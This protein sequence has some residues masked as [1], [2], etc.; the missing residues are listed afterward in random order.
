MTMAT[1]AP[2]IPRDRFGRPLV[3]PPNGGRPVAYT[4]CTTFVS[5]LEDTFNLGKWM[6]RMVALGL[7]DRPD[8]LLSV[9]AHR[10]D[11]SQLDRLCEDAR[12]YAKA[13]AAA[14]TG[15]AL[16]ALTERIDRGQDVGVVPDAYLADLA[17]YQGA[18]EGLTAT[19][20]EQFC[21]L[22]S[23]KIGGTPDRVVKYNGK[24]YIADVKTGS[25]EYGIGKIAMQ[26][27]VYA[28]SQ[29]YDHA[30]GA[31]GDHGAE[32]DKGLIVHL[33]A[34]AG[35]CDLIWVDL[36]EGWEG[37][38]LARAV[39]DW[40]THKFADLTEPFSPAPEPAPVQAQP[41]T[42]AEVIDQCLT[43]QALGEL[44]QERHADFTPAHV[45]QAKA[46]KAAITSSP[47]S[48]GAGSTATEGAQA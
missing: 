10:D 1:I 24:R 38:K 21:V 29:T 16:H 2:E 44:W 35:T 23:L 43:V 39:R 30:T 34:G 47:S 48:S 26:L 5:V 12:E 42:L 17:A 37:V 28:R 31:R 46:R 25:I 4:R 27:S 15:T 22:D 36:L 13:S 40:R 9:A 20:I 18:T 11:K 3:T 14:T 45:E 8:L 7:A 19:H 32:F 41:A 33:P 6:Q